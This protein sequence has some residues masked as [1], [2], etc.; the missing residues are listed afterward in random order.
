MLGRHLP[1]GLHPQPPL[2]VYLDSILFV[3]VLDM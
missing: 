3:L 1:E 2:V